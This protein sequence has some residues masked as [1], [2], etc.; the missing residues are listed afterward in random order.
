[1][2]AR[3]QCYNGRDVHGASGWKAGASGDR[4]GTLCGLGTVHVRVCVMTRI[5]GLTNRRRQGRYRAYGVDA[6]LPLPG[7]T[8]QQQSNTAAPAR[9]SSMFRASRVAFAKVL[10]LAQATPKG[11]S[12]ASLSAITAATKIGGEVDAFVAGKYVPFF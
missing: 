12:A 7:K 10:V 9:P 8:H 11:V 4:A 3:A 5:L 1:M 6:P 2:R